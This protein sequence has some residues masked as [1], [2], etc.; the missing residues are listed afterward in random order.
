EQDA[1][2]VGHDEDRATAGDALAGVVAL[3]PHDLLGT[4]VEGRGHGQP[5]GFVRR[6]STTDWTTVAT[7]SSG[8]RRRPS[9]ST[10]M[11][12]GQILRVRSGPPVA[13]SSSA[14]S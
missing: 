7:S 5:P 14:A 1:V 13:E 6:A 10:V 3:V 9:A 2:G 8:S 4:D 11:T 12:T